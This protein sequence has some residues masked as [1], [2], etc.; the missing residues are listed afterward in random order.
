MDTLDIPE[1]LEIPDPAPFDA[2]PTAIADFL[3]TALL[4]KLPGLLEAEFKNGDGR[5]LIKR[6]SEPDECIASFCSLGVFRSVLAR[7]G[8]HHMGVQLYG[9]HIRRSVC[10]NGK[11]FACEFFMANQGL[12]GYWIRVYAC[13]VT[14]D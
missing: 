4:R 8:F 3:M 9:G 1:M 12:S 6:P 11:T 2:D 5:C 7:F 13:A 10:Q 14:T